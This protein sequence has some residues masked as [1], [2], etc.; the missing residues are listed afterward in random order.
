MLPLT[1]LPALL[2]WAACARSVSRRTLAS[3]WWAEMASSNWACRAFSSAATVLMVA[4]GRSKQRGVKGL[5]QVGVAGRLLRPPRAAA[6][7]PGPAGWF[8]QAGEA[9]L[10]LWLTR[11]WVL[12]GHSSEG[13]WG[14]GDRGSMGSFPG[15]SWPLL[16]F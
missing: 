14:A 11:C 2:R 7:R 9:G 5:P 6:C 8:T 16:N 12:R 10:P 1:S 13:C 3:I 15:K 4:W